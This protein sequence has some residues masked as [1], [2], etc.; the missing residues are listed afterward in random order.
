MSICCHAAITQP[1]NGTITPILKPCWPR[2]SGDYT[3]L[4]LDSTGSWG[5]SAEAIG[6]AKPNASAIPF[7]F[8]DPDGSV[9]FENTFSY[10]PVRGTRMWTMDNVENGKHKPFGRVTLVP[11]H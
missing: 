9:T 3:C 8:K 6:R 2:S 7:G 10:D 5:I 1:L 11:R 4:W